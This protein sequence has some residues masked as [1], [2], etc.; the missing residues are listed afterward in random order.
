M[1]EVAVVLAIQVQC[2]TTSTNLHHN[3]IVQLGMIIPL[4]LIPG[5]PHII[6]LSS[7]HLDKQF[8]CLRL[9]CTGTRHLQQGW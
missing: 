8:G 2:T 5:E 1:H 3:I 9:Q 4:G 6:E 7:T